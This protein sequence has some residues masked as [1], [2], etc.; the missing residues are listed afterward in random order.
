MTTS[1]SFLSL[2]HCLY[3]VTTYHERNTKQTKDNIKI[4]FKYNK[5]Q[6]KSTCFL[7]QKKD[8]EQNKELKS[9]CCC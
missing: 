3:L 1:I 9:C 7:M 2:S 4:P 6:K 5:I 8:C